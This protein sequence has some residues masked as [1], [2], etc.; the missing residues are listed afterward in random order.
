MYLRWSLCTMYKFTRMPA[1]GYRRRLR[2][3]LLCLCDGLS[4]A[5]EL[6]C[7]LISLYESSG[8]PSISDCDSYLMPHLPPPLSR[9]PPPFIHPPP[10]PPQTPQRVMMIVALLQVRAARSAPASTRL[11]AASCATTATPAVPWPPS[12]T[13]ASSWPK[14]TGWRARARRW[15]SGRGSRC[16]ACPRAWRQWRCCGW[17]SRGCWIWTTRCSAS[18]AS[19]TWS[20][21]STP[22]R[23][24]RG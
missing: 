21:R 17:C 3:L 1:E 5:N 8:L 7:V 4:S 20:T 15:R 10:P 19:C 6:P 24:T 2:S 11:S 14:V 12:R 16:Q 22:A 18:G 9:P 23:P 13:G